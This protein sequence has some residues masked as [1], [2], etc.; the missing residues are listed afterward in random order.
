MFVAT[1]AQYIWIENRLVLVRLRGHDYEGDSALCGGGPSAQTVEQQNLN[2]EETQQQMSFDQ[3]LMGLFTQQYNNQQAQLNYIKGVMQPVIANAQA[4]NGFSTP[5]LASMRTQ[6]TDTISGAYQNAQKAL[7]INERASG[8][9][10]IPSGVTQGQ[11]EALLTSEAQT[12]S[13]TQNQITVA[14]AQ[15]A[16]QNLFNAANVLNGV[17]AQNSPAYLMGGSQQGGSI[18]AGLSGA[19][20]G[21]QNAVTNADNSGFFGQ[22]MTGLGSGMGSMLTGGNSNGSSGVGGFLG[23]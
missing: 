6:A 18:V 8:D 4:G 3:T 7:N 2:L 16:N 10:N 11:Q 5:E 21:L 13:N 19:Q 12:K 15:L 22:L 23:L 9:V 14:N 1:E 17:A 20:A